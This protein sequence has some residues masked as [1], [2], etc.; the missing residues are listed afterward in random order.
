MNTAEAKCRICGRT[1]II[2]FED[3]PTFPVDKLKEMALCNP[4]YDRRD[5]VRK[6]QHRKAQQTAQE[7]GLWYQQD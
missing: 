7:H 3:N 4:C 2:K 5:K 6:E 1:V